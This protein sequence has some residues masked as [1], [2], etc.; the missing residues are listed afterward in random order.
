MKLYSNKHQ[1]KL[2]RFLVIKTWRQF[3]INA[4]LHVMYF[5]FKVS[6]T[7]YVVKINEKGDITQI[8]LKLQ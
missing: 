2:T 4:Y 8:G 6:L 3:T 1:V 7:S 5:Q